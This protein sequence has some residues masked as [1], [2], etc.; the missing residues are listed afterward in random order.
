MTPG[1]SSSPRCSFS[2]LS[3]KRLS[4]DFFEL[5][6]LLAHRLDLRHRLVGLERKAPPLRARLLFEKRAGQYLI[7]LKA[8]GPGK[9]ALALERFGQTRIDVAIEDRLF[10]ITVLS[11][12]FDFLALDRLRALVFVDAMPVEDAHL[13]DRA[14]HAGRHAQRRVAHV[15]GLLPEDGAQ[16]FLFRGHRAFALRRDLADQ[17]IASDDLRP[18]VDNARLVEVLQRLL[19]NVRDVAGDFLGAELG[20]A[21]HR[22][23]FLNVDRGEDVVLDD[24]LGEQDRILEVVAVPRHEGDEDVPAKRQIAEIGRRPVGDDVALL[25]AIRHPHQRLLVDAGRL[26][27]SLELHQPVDVDAGFGRVGLVGRTHHDSGRVDLVDDARAARDDRRAQIARHDRPPCRCR[28]AARPS[29]PAARPDAAYS[30]PSA[31]DWRHH[32]RGTE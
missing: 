26:V 28:P 11:E 21:G 8:F 3:R 14:L 23:E 29:A 19:R 4:S 1:G 31:R 16:Q 7:L 24:A 20:V 27:R 25:D 5:V 22:L 17:D 12:A 13:D 32:S 2:T 15:G 10:V 6:V 30:S 9:R 18:D